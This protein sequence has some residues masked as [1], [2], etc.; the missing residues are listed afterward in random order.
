MTAI[1]L[2]TLAAAFT[3]G[4]SAT[5]LTSW[6]LAGR[7]GLV[8]FVIVPAAHAGDRAEYDA[9]IARLCPA[10]QSCFVNFFTNASGAPVALP[11]PDSIA[12]EAT[13]RYRRSMKNGMEVF[14]WSCR[15]S[16]HSDGCF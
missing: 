13:A 1:A 3:E 2:L 14:Q 15:I 16:K 7:Q 4:S 8:Q 6:Q 9:Q 11:L 12:A 5:D 10:D